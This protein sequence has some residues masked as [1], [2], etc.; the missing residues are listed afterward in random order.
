M[1]ACQLFFFS[2]PCECELWIMMMIEEQ[3]SISYHITERTK[4]IEEKLSPIISPIGNQP[5]KGHGWSKLEIAN[6]FKIS[7]KLWP[8]LTYLLGLTCVYQMWQMELTQKCLPQKLIICVFCP[9][10]YLFVF[11][12]DINVHHMHVFY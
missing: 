1:I 11:I 8:F 9:T 12:H 3:K 7:C 5:L 4:I 2:A 10:T 6:P